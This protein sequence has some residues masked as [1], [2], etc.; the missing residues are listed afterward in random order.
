[1]LSSDGELIEMAEGAAVPQ[2]V[3]WDASFNAQESAME[4]AFER[5][6]HFSQISAVIL[7]K[8]DQTYNFPTGSALRRASLITINRVEELRERLQDAM[9]NVIAENMEIAR[10]HGIAAPMI[11][12]MDV[13]I[14]WA[15]PLGI[16][17]D[18]ENAGETA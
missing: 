11:R 10:M 6:R 7:S 14:E 16:T 18:E 5:I 12:P 9:R 4:R 13:A 15:P 17:E 8:V 3:T 2:Y 1:M